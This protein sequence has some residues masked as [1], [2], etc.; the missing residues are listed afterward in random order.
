MQP[1][2]WYEFTT[3]EANRKRLE[4]HAQVVFGGSVFDL[5]NVFAVVIGSLIDANGKFMDRVGPS[6]RAIMRPGIGVDNV[7]LAAATQRSILVINTPDAPTE[8]TA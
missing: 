2:I 3:D 8:S 4:A 1:V 5:S 6:L 7:D